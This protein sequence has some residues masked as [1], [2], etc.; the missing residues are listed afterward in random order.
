LDVTTSNNR[1]GREDNINLVLKCIGYE[2]AG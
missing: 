1:S 2:C